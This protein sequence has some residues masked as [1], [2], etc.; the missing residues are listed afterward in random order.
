MK[1]LH[2][3][4]ILA[5][6][7]FVAWTCRGDPTASLRSGPKSLS[8]N[9][10]VM[11]I[12]EGEARGIEVRAL[13]DQLNAVAVPISATSSNTAVA[14]VVFD[15]GQVSPDAARNTFVVTAVAPGQ[16]TVNLSG[17]GLT[18]A[19]VVNV[20]PL[21]FGG[22]ISKANPQAGELITIA[23][24]SA[25]KFDPAATTVTFGGGNLGLIQ[26]ITADSIYVVTPFSDPGP[27]TIQN[28]V[29]TYVT[30]L[31]VSLPTATSVTQTG[32]RWGTGDN[33]Y[34]TAPSLTLP[35]AVGDSVQMITNFNA[36]SNDPMCGEG[37]ASGST[38]PCMIYKF[39][40]A[41]P[42][43]M[44]FKAD[45]STASDTADVDIYVCPDPIVDPL[46]DCFESGGSGASGR[47]PEYLRM[48]APAPGQPRVP[49][50]FTYPAGVHYLVVELYFGAAP[51]NVY[52][53]IWNK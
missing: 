43:S 9:P 38:G 50:P 25:L 8:I 37:T 29:V 46:N 27:L 20:L 47:F 18:D 3:G 14:T 17:G 4:A 53:T 35:A 22:T 40:L 6:T 1:R 34:A 15:S 30:G 48:L 42:T 24:T 2:Q 21:A 7:A 13:D 49:T 44:L 36:I 45:W 28:V 5:A 32:D 23:A 33:D 11:F 31:T 52:L 10:D 16:A 51:K 19:A 41:A 26:R 39:T 12:A